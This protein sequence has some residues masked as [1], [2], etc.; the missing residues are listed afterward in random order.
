MKRKHISSLSASGRGKNSR[1]CLRANTELA[2]VLVV[3]HYKKGIKGNGISVQEYNT[4]YAFILSGAPPDGTDCTESPRPLT[5][6][7][8]HFTHTLGWG[9]DGGDGS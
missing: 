2:L 5:L 7:Q 1:R 9:V 6:R 3:P 8:Y 4:V